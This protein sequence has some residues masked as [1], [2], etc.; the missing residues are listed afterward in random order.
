LVRGEVDLVG[1]VV[2]LISL[3]FGLPLALATHH[4]LPTG[5]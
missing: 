2:P 4:P 5:C 3:Q 1:H